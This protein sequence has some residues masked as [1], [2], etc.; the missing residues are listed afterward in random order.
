MKKRLFLI[1]CLSSILLV[2]APIF[3][4]NEN[5]EEYNQQKAVLIGETGNKVFLEPVTE[6]EPQVVAT[7]H[8][9]SGEETTFFKEALYEIT[10]S[11]FGNAGSMQD[12][13]WDGSRGIKAW[14][15]IYYSYTNSGYLLNAVEVNWRKEDPSL[16]LSN[17][18]ISAI[19]HGINYYNGKAEISQDRI[20]YVS[21]GHI[22]KYTNFKNPING[23]AYGLVG[24]RSNIK[25]TRGGSSWELNL[26]VIVY[27]SFG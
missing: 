20:W 5:T 21:P 23:T 13:K 15:K 16:S 9:V 17:A 27:Q 8:N 14:V 12:I 2:S 11:S 7:T 22:K 4:Y 10:P 24:G 19:C 1:A 3:A 25:I 18:T 26:P 6:S